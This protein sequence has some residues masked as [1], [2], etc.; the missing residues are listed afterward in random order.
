MQDDS[1]KKRAKKGEFASEMI[2]LFQ[3]FYS[4]LFIRG[5]QCIEP[6]PREIGAETAE[7]CNRTS[8]KKLVTWI[9]ANCEP[10]D[11]GTS[12]TQADVHKAVQDACVVPAKERSAAFLDAGMEKKS[13]GRGHH[14]YVFKFATKPVPLKL[15]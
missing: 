15:K 1:I 13:N 3:A 10:A 7:V 12:S 11:V 2:F 8:E 6:I 9:V 5:G 4:S 14:F